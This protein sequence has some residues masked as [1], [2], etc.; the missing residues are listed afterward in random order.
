M[1]VRRRTWI[2]E[3]NVVERIGE[4]RIEGEDELGGDVDVL[5]ELRELMEQRWHRRLSVRVTFE[6]LT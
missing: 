5:C 6:D 4:P 3:G 2:W 1:S